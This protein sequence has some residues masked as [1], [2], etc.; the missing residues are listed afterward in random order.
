MAM[1]GRQGFCTPAMF[2]LFWNF[3]II[4]MF[5]MGW[6]IV[7]VYLLAFNSQSLAITC[8]IVLSLSIPFFLGI[9]V[10]VA[11]HGSYVTFSAN[12]IQFG[13][14]QLHDVYIDD[15]I[16]N[17]HW[18]GY[19]CVDKLFGHVHSQTLYFFFYL[20]RAHYYDDSLY[21][22]IMSFLGIIA[23][24]TCI[25]RVTLCIHKFKRNHWLIW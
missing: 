1:I 4:M 22:V 8:Q 23:V 11:C 24:P 7:A 6:Y 10:I 9:I 3:V 25:L 20:W 21:I 13:L 14:D 17:I 12:V 19:I 18:Y 2:S 15:F 16:L 5:C